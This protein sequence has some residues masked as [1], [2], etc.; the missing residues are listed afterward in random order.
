MAT[1][2]R[3]FPE[4]SVPQSFKSTADGHSATETIEAEVPKLTGKLRHMV[5]TGKERVTVWKGGL[6]S[7]IRERPIQSVLIATA[8]GAVIGLIIG[9]RTR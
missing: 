3:A 1:Q 5:D 4:V 2:G 9:R 6:Q 8:V 7:G